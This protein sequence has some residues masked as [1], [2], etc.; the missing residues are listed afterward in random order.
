MWYQLKVFTCISYIELYWASGEWN[1]IWPW[2]ETG[3]HQ[4][5]TGL[6]SKIVACIKII[7]ISEYEEMGQ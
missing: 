6:L 1:N 4:E 3:G 7:Y 5:Q 2:K